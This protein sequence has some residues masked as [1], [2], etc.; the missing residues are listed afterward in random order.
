MAPG[1]PKLSQ[2]CAKTA[3]VGTALFTALSCGM[4]AVGLTK[5]RGAVLPSKDHL[6]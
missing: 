4:S 6:S 3:P 5:D 2:K 1:G